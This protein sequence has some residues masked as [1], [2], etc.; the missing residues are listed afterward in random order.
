M[1][2]ARRRIRKTHRRRV[3]EKERLMLILILSLI[4][5]AIYLITFIIRSFALLFTAPHALDAGNITAL[6]IVFLAVITASVKVFLRTRKYLRERKTYYL[7]AYYDQLNIPYKRF[8]KQRG[9]SYE[10]TVSRRLEEM[11][12][13]VAMRIGT[14]IRRKDAINEYAEIDILLFATSGIYV[15]EL[16]DYAGYVYGRNEEKYWTVGY[17]QGTRKKTYDFLNPVLQNKGHI[18]DLNKL[19]DALYHNIVIFSKKTEID[20]NISEIM[21][22][23][24]LVDRVQNGAPIYDAHTLK[25]LEKD[26]MKHVDRGRMNDHIRRVQYN[27]AKYSK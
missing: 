22:V 17:D 14:V 15:V 27:T 3:R 24:A 20:T 12:P 9:A 6:L 8:L 13:G 21:S 10:Y 23:E 18:D 16:K 2:T 7:S 5:L 26:I 4:A 11:L 25:T 19:V 1:P